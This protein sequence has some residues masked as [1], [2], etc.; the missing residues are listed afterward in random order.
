M[1]NNV[2]EYEKLYRQLDN[3]VADICSYNAKLIDEFPFLKPPST[4]YDYSYT[5]LDQL[6]LGWRKTFVPDMLKELKE[7]NF[8]PFLIQYKR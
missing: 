4:D 1:I 2:E 3:V 7:L 8:S 5:L 6:P